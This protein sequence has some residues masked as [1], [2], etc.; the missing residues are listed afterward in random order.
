MQRLTETQRRDL[1]LTLE[2][3]VREGLAF[4]RMRQPAGAVLS[5]HGI[6]SAAGEG[7]AAIGIQ[8]IPSAADSWPA[9][10]FTIPEYGPWVNGQPTYLPRFSLADCERIREA[11]R[12]AGGKIRSSWNGRGC[13]SYSVSVKATLPEELVAALSAYLKGCS[14]CGGTVF[15]EKP[16][17]AWRRAFRKVRVPKGWR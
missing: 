6:S 9:L 7:S 14:S 3:R 5:H 12:R 13:W 11:V 10:V 15:C 17:H 2:E 4:L 1:A 16:R 8:V